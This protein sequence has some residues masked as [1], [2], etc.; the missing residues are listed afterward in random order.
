[1]SDTQV[2]VVGKSTLAATSDG[3]RT[4]TMSPLPLKGIK[5]TAIVAGRVVVSAGKVGVESADDGRTWTELS[6]PAT[7][8]A[9]APPVKADCTG[10][11]PAAG[12]TCAVTWQV[13]S[14]EGLPEVRSLTFRGEVG[15]AMGDSALV[16]FTA[17]GGAT[18]K[19]ASG[20]V[21]GYLQG[22]DVKGDRVVV[23]DD[24]LASGGTAEATVKL[25]RQLGGE[26]VGCGFVVELDF[27][28]GRARLDRVPV[29]SLVH[30]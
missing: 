16:A 15:L 29:T 9:L 11:L 7:L 22:F 8:A 12:E 27:L 13:T 28:D 21:L 17:D 18:W 26:V 20:F 3:G 2:F 23:V 4:W 25:V 1:V 14:P 5:Q 6:D 19:T 10:R 24:L 30:F